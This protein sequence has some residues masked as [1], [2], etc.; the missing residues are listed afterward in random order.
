MQVADWPKDAVS[1]QPVWDERRSPQELE[2][3]WG[4]PVVTI[5]GWCYKGVGPR[6]R[7]LGEHVRYWW[8]DVLQWLDAAQDR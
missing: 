1:A 3:R 4:V 6:R 2:P 8:S 5:Y 7:R